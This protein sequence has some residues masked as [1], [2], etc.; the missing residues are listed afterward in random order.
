MQQWLAKQAKYPVPL[1]GIGVAMIGIGIWGLVGHP[2]DSHTVT[3][4][5]AI[6]LGIYLIVCAI[7]RLREQRSATGN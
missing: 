2:R 4:V 7:A 6:P 3:S 1:L 5:T